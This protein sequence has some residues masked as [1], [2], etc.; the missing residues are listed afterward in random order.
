MS[1][2]AIIFDCDGTLVD[3]DMAHYTAWVRALK[4]QGREFALEEFHPF[5]GVPSEDTSQML[6]EKWGK[7]CPKEL[8]KDKYAIF[9]SLMKEEILPINHTL[10]F[11]HRLVKE[12]PRFKYKLAVASGASARRFIYT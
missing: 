7:I 5:V 11:L 2:K 3:T 8:V 10:A 1:V 12:Q 6:A 9:G 4:K